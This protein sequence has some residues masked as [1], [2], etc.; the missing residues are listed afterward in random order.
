L[1][2][3]EPCPAASRRPRPRD[4]RARD[5]VTRATPVESVR[6]GDGPRLLSE[7]E[8]SME[9]TWKELRRRLEAAGASEETMEALRRATAGAR[10]ARR[11]RRVVDSALEK[12]RE[13]L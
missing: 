2:E 9:T 1:S 6:R 5:R 11:V 8:E 7:E 3:E 12:A 13:H 10:H 4:A